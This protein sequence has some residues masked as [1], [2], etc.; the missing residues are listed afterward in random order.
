MTPST[1]PPASANSSSCG[2]EVPALSPQ[3]TQEGQ[4]ACELAKMQAVIE[5]LL[6]PAGCPWDREQTPL[7][8]CDYV[9]E[10]AHELVDAIRHGAPDDVREELGDVLFLLAFIATLYARRGNFTL[11]GAIAGNAAKMVRRHPHVFGEAAAGSA[12]DVL[13]IWDNVKLSEKSAADAQASIP[14][15]SGLRAGPYISA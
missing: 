8:L 9:L 15:L 7:S 13:S 3:K 1:T 12:E 11:D 14:V 10:E 4:A 2:Q 6:A 5:A